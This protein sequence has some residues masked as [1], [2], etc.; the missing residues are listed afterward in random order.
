MFKDTF[1]VANT[2]EEYINKFTNNQHIINSKYIRQVILGNCNPKRHITYE[3]YLID[4]V[5]TYLINV[6]VSI[7]RVV[8]FSNDEIVVDISD[9]EDSEKELIRFR[10]TLGMQD[11]SIPLK[12]EKYIKRWLNKIGEEQLRRL[13]SVR[14]S[15]IKGQTLG[16]A[17]FNSHLKGAFT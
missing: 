5:L 4:T 2:W 16:K 17:K 15:D 10:I 8:F 13:L 1:G 9:M 12:I 3:K 14:L 7:D 6:Y 11:F